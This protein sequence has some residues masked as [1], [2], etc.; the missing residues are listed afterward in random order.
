VGQFLNE[1]SDASSAGGLWLYADLGNDFPQQWAD[2][3][4]GGN[5]GGELQFKGSQLRALLPFFS[6]Q[7]GVAIESVVLVAE[8][9]AST[10]GGKTLELTAGDEVLSFKLPTSGQPTTEGRIVTLV[11]DEFEGTS[12]LASEDWSLSIQEDP[13]TAPANAAK[14]LSSLQL[15]LQYVIQ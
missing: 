8:Y 5:K 1:S 4:S 2:F 13:F 6:R 7:A 3:R 12:S 9:Q 15:L 10:A 14:G 11:R